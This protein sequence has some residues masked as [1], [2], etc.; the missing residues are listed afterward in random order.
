LADWPFYNRTDDWYLVIDQEYGPKTNYSNEYLAMVY[1][2]LTP[3]DN[4][5]AVLNTA[6]FLG[7]MLQ[8]ILRYL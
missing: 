6:L 1:D 5:A 7:A 8:V 3:V 2:S 4:A